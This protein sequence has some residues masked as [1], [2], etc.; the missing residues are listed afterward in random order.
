MKKTKLGN[1]GIALI[2]LVVAI[3][4]L[5]IVSSMMIYNARNGVKMRNLK[6]MQND[7]EVLTD[8]VNAY[9]L[10]YGK[11]PIKIEYTGTSGFTK[12]PNDG[13]KYYVIDLEA[14]DGITLNYGADYK[15]IT[16]SVENYDDLYIVNEQSHHV[17]YV[18]GIMLDGVMYYTTDEDSQIELISKK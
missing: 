18:R 14:L 6:L 17:Y 3:S 9:Y 8:K 13:D 15:K 5:I 7:I 16:T 10:K 12:Q 2:T 4:I 1:K 11:L